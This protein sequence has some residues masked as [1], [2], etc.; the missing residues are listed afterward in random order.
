MSISLIVFISSPSCCHLFR[1]SKNL[2]K[3][4]GRHS[5]QISTLDLVPLPVLSY[6]PFFVN[7]NHQFFCLIKW[8][9]TRPIGVCIFWWSKG[10]SDGLKFVSWKQRVIQMRTT[11]LTLRIKDNY[12]W[13]QGLW[14]TQQY[15]HFFRPN[16]W[17]K[18]SDFVFYL[19]IYFILQ[20]FWSKR[21]T[22]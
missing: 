13:L 19:F 7:E 1:C 15:G 14:L 17:I 18:E 2:H 10:I 6:M 3:R 16:L 22:V 12:Q 11:V 9:L 21:E 4:S 8:G 5:F 20:Y